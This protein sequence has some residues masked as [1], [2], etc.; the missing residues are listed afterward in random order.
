MT[1]TYRARAL[2]GRVV[3]GNVRALTA[4]AVYE[5][6]RE[7][8]LVPSSIEHG[9]SGL[10]L[11]AI[12]WRPSIKERL[13]FFRA[14]ASLEQC[15]IDFSTAFA[16]LI[17]QAR[18]KRFRDALIA[19]RSSVELR[20]EKLHISMSARPVEFTDLEV[21]MVAAGEE[22]GNREDIFDRLASLLEHE[23]G[24]RKR[25]QSALAYPAIVVV[26]AIAITLYLFTVVVPEFARLFAGFGVAPTGPMSA[27][28]AISDAVTRPVTLLP[29]AFCLIAASVA[30]VKTI[31]TPSGALYANRLLL[32]TPGIGGFLRKSIVART[33]RVL[34]TLLQAGVS[35]TRALEI[36][37]PVSSSPVYAKDLERARER[38][39]AG[40]SASLEEAVEALAVF[41]ALTIAFIRVGSRAGNT[42]QM[43]LKAAE[44]F[45]EELNALV[46]MIPAIVQT[47]VTVGMG[48]V[49]ALIVYVVYVPLSSLAANIH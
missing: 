45:E 35:Q 29:A 41:D 34:S 7:R 23:H 11:P 24:A 17:D 2:D 13:A 31:R 5:Q 20:G 36:A 49:V 18:S 22:A 27:L 44:Y 19:I 10:S 33:L 4:R 39:L 47:V 46:T 32:R 26:I 43:M 8:M 42:P 21:A 38:L 9:T 30:L 3:K 25:F 6:L 16:I 48:A 40:L 28:L 14:F 12:L 37:A 15:G 1:F